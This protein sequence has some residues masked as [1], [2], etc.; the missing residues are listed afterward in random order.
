MYKDV[1]TYIS[2]AEKSLVQAI[3]YSKTHESAHRYLAYRD[4]PNI[5]KKYRSCLSGAKALDYGTGTGYSANFLHELGF[6]VIGLD[7]SREMLEQ[8]KSNYPSFPFYQIKDGIIPLDSKN[9]DLIFSS[10]V[11]FE[12]GSEEKIFNYLSEAKRVMKYNGLFLAITGSENLHS[13]SKK[14][15]NFR[16]DY[17]ENIN[18]KAGSLVKLYHYESGIKFT[19]YYWKESCYRNFLEKAGFKLLEIHYP[20]GGLNEPYDW[21]DEL[22]VSP[23]VILVAEINN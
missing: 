19:D 20:L 4:I 10:F 16:T 13:S 18:P 1:K 8:A 23:F 7:V 21:K 6:D 11:L 5:L 15:L 3:D 9:F 14:W 12:I 22:V 2:E 17:P